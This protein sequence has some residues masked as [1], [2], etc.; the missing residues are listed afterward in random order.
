MNKKIF[1]IFILIALLSIMPLFQGQ[2]ITSPE[3]VTNFNTQTTEEIQDTSLTPNQT[4]N[5]NESKIEII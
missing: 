5:Y 4:F 1:Y 2:A 3:D